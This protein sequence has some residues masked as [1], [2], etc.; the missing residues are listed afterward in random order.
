M[1]LSADQLV[2]HRDAHNVADTA[3][4]AQVERAELLDVPDQADDCPGD[5]PADE[6][7]AA[8]DPDQLN[9]R[10]NIGLVGLRAHHDDH[11]VLLSPHH[12]ESPGPLWPGAS[13]QV[14]SSAQCL[15]GDRPHA[16]PVAVEKPVRVTHGRK[17][18]ASAALRGRRRG[19]AWAGKGEVSWT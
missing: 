12:D 2:G 11:D 4:A 15:A 14:V 16:G 1:M 19:T 8:S 3:P 10:V 13:V 18:S 6:S 9:D 5:S 17:L 7:F